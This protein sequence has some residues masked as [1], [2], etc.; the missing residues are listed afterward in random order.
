MKIVRAVSLTL[1]IAAVWGCASRP[2]PPVVSLRAIYPPQDYALS[3]AADGITVAAVP[4]APGRDVYGDPRRPVD[5][6]PATGLNVLNAGVLPVR[7]IVWNPTGEEI[8]LDPEQITGRAD[9]V[10]YRL[11]APEDAV[12][13]V[14]GSNE[15]KQAIKGSQVGPVVQ[16]LLG[17]ELLV[18]AVRGGV[19]G[20]ASGGVAGGASGAASG[21]TGVGLARARGYE[22]SMIGLITAEYKSHAL[23]RR[24]LYP[25]STVDGLVFLPSTVGI[26]HLEIR[27]YAPVTKRAIRLVTPVR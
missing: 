3:A 23:S 4:F 7:L 1:V 19:S 6:A 27:L 8:V 16:S 10:A 18:E 21:A 11:Y 5:A 26:T 9:G 2:L 22:K 17:G 12:T 20:A 25:G 24:N 14:T 15:F 13:I